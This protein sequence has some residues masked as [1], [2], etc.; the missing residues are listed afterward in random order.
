MTD[1]EQVYERARK[2]VQE[3]KGFYVHAL[4]YLLVN[5][6]LLVMDLLTPG[7]PWFYWPMLGWGIGLAAHGLGTFGL[8]G[9]FGADWEERK[10]RELV[11]R[12]L[13]RRDAATR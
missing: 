6:A 13:Q 9:L 8:P 10:T 11:E 2:R 7:G 12:E 1:D 4:M 5:V 3:L